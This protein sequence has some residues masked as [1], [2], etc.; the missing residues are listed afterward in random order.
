MLQ[1]WLAVYRLA[2]D[3]IDL[4]WMM[5]CVLY[6]AR[7]WSLSST[8]DSESW[9]ASKQSQSHFFLFETPLYVDFIGLNAERIEKKNLT[10][11]SP[12]LYIM[13]YRVKFH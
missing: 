13:I 2:T 12:P 6:V 10:L 1:F 5:L 3:F 11:F 9:A 4:Q 7:V 8:Q